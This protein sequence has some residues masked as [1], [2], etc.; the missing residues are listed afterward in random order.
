MLPFSRSEISAASG[1]G[2]DTYSYVPRV[3][4]DP[5]VA[6]LLGGRHKHF[7]RLLVFLGMIFAD[8]FEELADFF[9]REEFRAGLE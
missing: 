7:H 3:L 1:T 6:L 5:P 9:R 8:G 2:G 4:V